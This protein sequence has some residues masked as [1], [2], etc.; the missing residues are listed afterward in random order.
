MFRLRRRMKKTKRTLAR[1]RT[2]RVS[3]SLS[4]LFFVADVGMFWHCVVWELHVLVCVLVC[5]GMYRFI[6][7]RRI[8]DQLM[9]C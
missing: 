1:M 9:I 5:F 3:G 2:D 7:S 4:Q 8:N 6:H